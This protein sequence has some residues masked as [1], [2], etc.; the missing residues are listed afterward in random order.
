MEKKKISEDFT[1][2]KR[3]F[4]DLVVNLMA[5]IEKELGLKIK[6]FNNTKGAYDLHREEADRRVDIRVHYNGYAELS[7][8]RKLDL[9]EKCELDTS[10]DYL[11]PVYD[12]YFNLGEADDLE[13]LLEAIKSYF[14][15]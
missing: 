2:I 12:S 10:K 1:E 15:N 14:V 11:D 3:R 4:A 13:K 5:A 6:S 7:L 8:Q 9:V